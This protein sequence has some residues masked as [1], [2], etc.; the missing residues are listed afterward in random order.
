MI[1]TMTDHEKLICS[2]LWNDG[3][4]I[5]SIAKILPYRIGTAKR[6]IRGLIASGYLP[7]RKKGELVKERLKQLVESGITDSYEIASILG[8]TQQT[9]LVYKS[10]MRLYTARPKKNY[11]PTVLS[12]KTQQLIAELENGVSSKE[13]RAKYGVSR[14]YVDKVKSKYIK[15]QKQ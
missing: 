7:P 5:T 12:E 14:Q 15:G 10:Q 2:T 13:I 9:A 4:S 8:I 3:E 6:L 1:T 11:R